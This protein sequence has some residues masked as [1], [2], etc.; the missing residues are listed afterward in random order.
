MGAVQRESVA[1]HPGA[2]WEV[3]Q[4]LQSVPTLA[5]K[6]AVAAVADEGHR[7]G[8]CSREG[9]LARAL[10]G[11]NHRQGTPARS[12]GKKSSAAHE[13]LGRSRGGW[14][15]KIHR[16][17]DGAGKPLCF[18]L[19]PGQQHEATVA[20][21]LLDTGGVKRGGRGQPKRRPERIVADKG[22]SSRKFRQTLQRG[23]I[24]ITIPR[25]SNEEQRGRP[26][27]P[28]HY[29]QRNRIER[30]FNRLKQFRRLA[31]RYEKRAASYAAL[32]ALA[33]VLLWL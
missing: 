26:C 6:R 19:T 23:G 28:E 1:G 5:Q 18:I 2:V 11:R 14:T 13:A 7:A 24:R 10:P 32:F 30:C 21:A 29:R 3:D 17:T 25:R 31:T 20:Q 27:D 33:C 9:Q 4:H 12:R 15:T 16:R 22:Y 8:R